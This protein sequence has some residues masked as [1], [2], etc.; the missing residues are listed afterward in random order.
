MSLGKDI[1]PVRFDEKQIREVMIN[2]IQ[3]AVRAMKDGG[4]L[5]LK[6]LLNEENVVVQVT[7]TGEGIPERNMEKIFSPFFSTREGG[8]GL[9]LSIVQR[10]VESHGGKI[11]CKSSAGK[12]TTFEITLPLERIRTER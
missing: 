1:P 12:G 9:G 10:I 11:T 8:L 3:N 6:T 5:E 7:D 4:E 2:L